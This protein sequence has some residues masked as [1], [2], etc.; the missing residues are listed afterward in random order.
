MSGSGIVGALE[1]LGG[2]V[3]KSGSI[4]S[5]NGYMGVQ[6]PYLIKH[7]P[8]DNVPSAFRTLKGYPSN[9]SGVLGSF[10]GYAE[11]DNIDLT[12]IST[13]LGGTVAT[14]AELE[15]IQTLLRGGIFI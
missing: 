9:I 5:S 3:Q 1:A 4:G 2:D 15:E 6:K 11:I 12:N 7:I 10:S 13:G 8:K 14:A